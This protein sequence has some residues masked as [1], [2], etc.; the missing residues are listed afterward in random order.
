[1]F[2]PFLTMA[3]DGKCEALTLF[4]LHI[5]TVSFFMNSGNCLK[6]VWSTIR[7]GYAELFLSVQNV[8]LGHIDSSSRKTKV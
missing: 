8:T 7:V 5:Y 4:P 1:M 2:P 6:Q 3:L